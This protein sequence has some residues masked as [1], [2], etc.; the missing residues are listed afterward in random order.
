M[1]TDAVGGVWTY[2]LE[3]CNALAAH[4]VAVVLAS[5]GP[6]P[7]EAQRRD[8]ACI[9]NLHLTTSEYKLEWMDEPW[10]DVERA[11]EWLLKLA[12]DEHVDL[13]HL[14]GYSHAVLPWKKP[15]VVVAHSCVYTWWHAVHGSRPPQAWEHYRHMVENGLNHASAIVAPTEAFLAYLRRS[16]T[17]AT[18]QCVIPNARSA[19][20]LRG[21]TAKAPFVLASGRL[22][23]EAKNLR[24][25][26]E[27]ASGLA[28]P[29]LAAGETISPDGT[30]TNAKHLRC[31]GTQTRA[32]LGSLL[33]RAAIFA[34][35]ALYEPFGLS[36]L[37]AA[38]AGCALVLADI[39]TLREL[40]NGAAWFVDPRDSSAVRDALQTLIAHDSQRR[41]LSER[42]RQRAREFRVERMGEAYRSLYE[43]VLHPSLPERSVA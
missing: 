41:S 31:L 7:S 27:A 12:D 13:L 19:A 22:W 2:A 10:S 20:D 6:L 3:L 8:A 28:W 39:P 15:V 1:T 21:A 33:K 4:D 9:A 11:G 24:V 32:Q 26:D 17:F 42:A 18:P 23:D 36:V 14:N 38:H 25:L 43:K 30:P 35:P 16:Y 34:H 29:I 40:W 5:M 37:E